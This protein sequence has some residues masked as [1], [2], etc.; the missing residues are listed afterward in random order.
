[1]AFLVESSAAFLAALAAVEPLA[2]FLA[3]PVVAALAAAFLAAPV[4]V[5][6]AAVERVP[7]EG[8]REVRLRFQLRI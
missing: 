6:L 7:A 1:V 8:R 2:E 5:G 4:E 3:A